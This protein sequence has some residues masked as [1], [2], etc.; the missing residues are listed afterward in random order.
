MSDHCRHLSDSRQ[1][2]RA[3]EFSRFLLHEFFKV[4]RVLRKLLFEVL[5]LDG[6]VDGAFEGIYRRRAFHE[7]ILRTFTHRLYRQFQ[8]V[9]TSQHDDRHV[10]HCG[11]HRRDCGQALA[12]RKAQIEQH[13]VDTSL[14]APFYPGI[15]TIHCIKRVLC[16]G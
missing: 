6:I 12:V 14:V 8:I 11:A 4:L 9:Q 10:W 3:L 15:E 13:N 1:A 16:R 2:F 5:A 7:I